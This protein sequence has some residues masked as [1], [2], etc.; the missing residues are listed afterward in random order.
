MAAQ[1][2]TR[3]QANPAEDTPMPRSLCGSES[4]AGREADLSELTQLHQRL[5]AAIGRVLDEFLE[6]TELH[7]QYTVGASDRPSVWWLGNA[8][9]S[10]AE[11]PLRIHLHVDASDRSAEAALVVHI[12]GVAER[13]PQNVHTLGHVLHRETG[14][15]VEVQGSQG[16]TEV[17]P[18][19]TSRASHGPLR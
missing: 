19:A 17:W 5:D 8:H 15:R 1:R 3:H 14:H 2:I 13:V 18:Q 10:V 4:R 7:G 16:H 9:T 12:Q 6:A 11:R